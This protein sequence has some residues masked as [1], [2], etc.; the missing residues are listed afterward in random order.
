M[1][2]FRGFFCICDEMTGRVSVCNI[3]VYPFVFNVLMW[4]V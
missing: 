2:L 3:G 4:F 1:T